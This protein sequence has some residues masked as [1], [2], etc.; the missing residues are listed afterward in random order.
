M[1]PTFS[2]K[3][4]ALLEITIESRNLFPAPDQ[5]ISAVQGS[6]WGDFLLLLF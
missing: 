3:S 5:T 4:S 6:K 1:S 2:K